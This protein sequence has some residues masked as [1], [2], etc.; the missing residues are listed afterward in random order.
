MEQ[1][2]CLREIHCSHNQVGTVEWHSSHGHPLAVVDLSH[3]HVSSQHCLTGL[4]GLSQLEMVNLRGNPLTC[5][6]K[7]RENWNHPLSVTIVTTFENVTVMSQFAQHKD[8]AF[9]Q[10]DVAVSRSNTPASSSPDS[11]SSASRSPK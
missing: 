1:Y 4:E 2:P 9:S 10:P 11:S 8:I 5:K 3:N 6:P 7:W